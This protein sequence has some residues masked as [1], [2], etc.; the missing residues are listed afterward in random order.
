MSNQVPAKYILFGNWADLIL[1][2]WGG[3]DIN[4]DTA[5]LSTSGGVRVVTLQDIDVAIRHAESFAVGYKA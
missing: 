1:G 4:T 3:L 2:Y 5:T